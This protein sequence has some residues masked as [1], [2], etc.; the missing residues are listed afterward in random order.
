MNLSPN[1]KEVDFA[2]FKIQVKFIIQH[3]NSFIKT[4]NP[5]W[6]AKTFSSSLILK[7]KRVKGHIKNLLHLTEISSCLVNA[8]NNIVS[9][10]LAS[11]FLLLTP[12]TCAY[13]YF[14]LSL[15]TPTPLDLW[16]CCWG[17]SSVMCL[18]RR[19][20]RA[21]WIPSLHSWQTWLI[22]FL[23]D[24]INLD[25]ISAMTAKESKAGDYPC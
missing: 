5:S 19:H 25:F 9:V 16:P 20:G 18:Q 3:K 23:R 12:F 1:L 11:L 13:E 10:I 6:H 15:S 21:H 24:A 17:S 22:F 14:Y 8:S 4:S 2:G 7:L